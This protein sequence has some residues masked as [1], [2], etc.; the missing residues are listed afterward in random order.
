ML[1]PIK[2]INLLI[3]ITASL[4][5][6][7]RF[8][9][10]SE[11]VIPIGDSP[12]DQ[13]DSNKSNENYWEAALDA[14]MKAAEAAQTATTAEEWSNVAD[15]WSDAIGNLEAISDS[16]HNIDEVNEKIESYRENQKIARLRQDKANWDTAL[17]QGMKAAEAA[18]SVTSP[19]GW[20]SVSNLWQYAIDTLDKISK[21]YPE[22]GKVQE[23]LAEYKRNQQAAQTIAAQQPATRDASETARTDQLSSVEISVAAIDAYLRNQDPSGIL[24]VGADTL[25]DNDYE[26]AIVVTSSWS[27]LGD[28]EKRF[29]IEEFGE[30]WQEKRSPR[31]PSKAILWIVEGENIVGIYDNRGVTL[32]D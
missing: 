17:N 19:S 14:G 18:Q 27:L 10:S 26:I 24:F 30:I 29:F 21:D 31:D 6:G 3:L 12:T 13:A 2:T 23:K 5:V 16:A 25:P 22:Y 32:R 7:C 8:Y 15:L 28:R 9:P 1:K 11:E 4:I 20:E